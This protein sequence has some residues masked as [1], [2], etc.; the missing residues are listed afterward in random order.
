[1]Q[2]PG[3]VWEGYLLISSSQGLKGGADG[4]KQIALSPGQ[5]TVSL[6]PAFKV[7]ATIVYGH[8]LVALCWTLFDDWILRPPLSKK[9]KWKEGVL[10]ASSP[11]NG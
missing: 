3:A 8:V 1:M 7:K 11:Q 10:S 9:Q 2:A 6:V 4:C 5:A